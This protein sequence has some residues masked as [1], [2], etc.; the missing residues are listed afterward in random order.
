MATNIFQSNNAFIACEELAQKDAF[1]TTQMTGSI[2]SAV[3]SSAFDVSLNHIAPKQ[4]GTSRLAFNSLNRQPDVRLQFSYYQNY[5]YFNEGFVNLVDLN[6]ATVTGMDEVPSVGALSGLESASRNFYILTRP[7]QGFDALSGF[8][9]GGSPSFSGYQCASIGNCYLTDYSL[10]YSV[11]QLPTVSVQ[12]LGSNMQYE[13]VTGQILS[14]PAINLSGGN[15]DGVGHLT[16]DGIREFDQSPTIM[17]P[18]STGSS[19]TLQNLQV[20]GQALSGN[21]ALQSVELN[22]NIPRVASYGLGSDYVYDRKMQ[23]P[24][25]GILNASSLVSGFN[26]GVLSGVLGSESGYNFDLV[27][28]GSG[29][30][31]ISYKIQDAKLGSYSYSMG[32]NG[33]MDLN[34]SFTFELYPNPRGLQIKGNPQE[35]LAYHCEQQIASRISPSMTI[36]DNGKMLVDFTDPDGSLTGGGYGAARSGDFWGADIDFTSV[37]VWNNK[38]TGGDYR[39]RGGVAIT[40]RHMAWA[41]HCM[42]DDGNKVWF[43]EPDGTWIER[44]LTEG[45]SHATADIAVGLLNEDLPDT[46]TPSKVFPSDVNRYLKRNASDVIQDAL[47]R[48][49]VVGFDFEKKGVLMVST[50]VDNW[51]Y[52]STVLWT[53][54]NVPYPFNVLTE[55]IVA[56]DS[57][58][59]SFLIVDGVAVLLTCWRTAT[60][61]PSYVKWRDDINTLIAGVDSDAGIDTGYKLE[62]I[63]LAPFNFKRYPPL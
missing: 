53:D 40:K 15:A 26:A 25:R 16:F 36:N 61:G 51:E 8:S 31:N 56:N 20:G 1:Y 24:V 2:V 10:S 9:E 39:M 37:S 35:S 12:F 4:V 45:R 62:E 47:F 60:A 59:P 54:G 50:A 38:G 34:T 44:T 52:N 30:K 19:A 49:I 13:E 23:L 14:S 32:V 21:H 11:G 55:A 41:K 46:I 42:L 22:I 18:S 29:N 6:N 27:L 33:T 63:D 17:N 48:P 58:M 3:Q 5:P 28:E 57:G 43:V 7:D